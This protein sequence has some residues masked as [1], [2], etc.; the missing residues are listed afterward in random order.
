VEDARESDDAP[1]TADF[2]E[3]GRSVGSGGVGIS[4]H[5]KSRGASATSL[6]ARPCPELQGG[7]RLHVLPRATRVSPTHSTADILS[8]QLQDAN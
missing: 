1:G 8:A 2:A 5:T 6:L 3:E 4:P 7:R